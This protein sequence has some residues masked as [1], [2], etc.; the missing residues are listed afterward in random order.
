MS[1]RRG[2]LQS[3]ASSPSSALPTNLPAL[4]LLPFLSLARLLLAQE[5]LQ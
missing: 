4:V 3:L 5:L 2:R 1:Q